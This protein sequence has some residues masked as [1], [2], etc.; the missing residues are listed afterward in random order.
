MSGVR[1]DEN[2]IMKLE[3][4]IGTNL[5]E[6]FRDLAKRA[7]EEIGNITKPWAEALEKFLADG[8][9]KGLLLEKTDKEDGTYIDIRITKL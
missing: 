5:R 2:K 8:S 9:V 7:P 4:E 6:I 1:R 3:I